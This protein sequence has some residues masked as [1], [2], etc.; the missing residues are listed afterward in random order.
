MRF[1]P[2]TTTWGWA[3]WHRAWAILTIPKLSNILK[4]K[5]WE[6]LF[7]VNG[8]TDYLSMLGIG[9]QVEMILG[10]FG[11]TLFSSER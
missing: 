11:G 9:S 4:N 5:E 1:L 3:T 2:I 6:S 8:A 7:Y 10:F